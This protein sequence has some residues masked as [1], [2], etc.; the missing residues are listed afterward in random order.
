MAE[1]I[2]EARRALESWHIGQTSA[3]YES[4]GRGAG[5]I[6]SGKGDHGGVPMARTNSP[7]RREL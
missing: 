1:D 6:S 7:A 3:R 5:V 4:S 2:Q